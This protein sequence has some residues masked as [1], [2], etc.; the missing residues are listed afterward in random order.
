MC[1]QRIKAKNSDA[2]RMARYRFLRIARG[3]SIIS[4]NAEQLL[5]TKAIT[6]EYIGEGG[7]GFAIGVGIPNCIHY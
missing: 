1:D 5:A 2:P 3:E 6:V 4:T 7:N